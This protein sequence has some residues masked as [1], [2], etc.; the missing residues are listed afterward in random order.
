MNRR[1]ELAPRARR[2][3]ERLSPE[4]RLRVLVDIQALGASPFGP[5]GAVKKL[6]GYR[7]PTYRLRSGDYRAVYRVEEGVVV[8]AAVFDRKD[9]ARELKSLKN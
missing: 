9:L 3:V 8:V 2:Q 4:I 7:T 6:R 5:P 1:V